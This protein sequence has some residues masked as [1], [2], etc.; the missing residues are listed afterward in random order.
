MARPA[1]PAPRPTPPPAP[2]RPADPWLTGGL[3][4]GAVALAAGAGLLEWMAGSARDEAAEFDALGDEWMVH[5]GPDRA[6]SEREASVLYEDAEGKLATAS[7][8]RVAAVVSG[9]LAVAAAGAAGYLWLAEPA[10]AGSGG[11]AAPA[12]LAPLLLAGPKGVHA[13]VTVRF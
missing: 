6:A 7:A 11:V 1:R 13:G 2:G 9:V 12:G 4:A 10:R 5:P 8:L 3:A